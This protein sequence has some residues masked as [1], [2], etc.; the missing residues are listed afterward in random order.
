MPFVW[1]TDVSVGADIDA[2][3]RNETKTNIEWLYNALAANW[4][5]NVR[6]PACGGAGFDM[7]A[8]C[9]VVWD[10]AIGDDIYQT[11]GAHP[12]S[13]LQEAR[14][15]LDWIDDNKCPVDNAAFDSGEDFGEDSGVNAGA[16]T[17]EDAGDNVGAKVG[18]DTGEDVG[19]NVG[20]NAG[21][22]NAEDVSA[23]SGAN[24]GEDSGENVSA[25]SGVDAGDNVAV[26]VG[27][28]IG[29]ETGVNVSAETVVN[30]GDNIGAF[31]IHDGLHRDADCIADDIG[32]FSG[33]E[34]ENW[35]A[36]DI[37]DEISVLTTDEVCPQA[38]AVVNYD[39]H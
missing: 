25:N 36:N 16:N 17:G 12:V 23:D 15:K 18:E 21:E 6:F 32:H 27:D 13:E 28:D 4:P 39:D 3:D 9:S 10:I 29:V 19:A 30:I 31:A 37:F 2:A 34:T 35:V 5:G 24:V 38:Y 7:A 1:A 33:V 22:D 11:P 14:D 26:D 8:P 20:A